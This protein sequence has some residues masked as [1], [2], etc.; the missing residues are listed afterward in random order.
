MILDFSKYKCCITKNIVQSVLDEQQATKDN[1]EEIIFGKNFSVGEAAFKG[2]SNLKKIEN[3]RFADSI[4]PEAFAECTTL[5]EVDLRYNIDISRRAFAGCSSLNKVIFAP[6]AILNE[7]AFAD[8]PKLKILKNIEKISSCWK[9][10]FSNDSL[11]D[12]GLLSSKSIVQNQIFN[13]H[14]DSMLAQMSSSN[15]DLS[16]LK[17]LCNKILYE[18]HYNFITLRKPTVV[19]VYRGQDK[20]YYYMLLEWINNFRQF[21]PSNVLDLHIVLG[22]DDYIE[23]VE[24]TKIKN[25]LDCSFDNVFFHINKNS[26]YIA[27][28][29]IFNV[30]FEDWSRYTNVLYCDVDIVV[31]KPLD[32]LFNISL[33]DGKWL[34]CVPNDPPF[35][36]ENTYKYYS[37]FIPEQHQ[38]K[39]QMFSSTP[40]FNGGMFMFYTKDLA[41]IQQHINEHNDFIYE[42]QC[43]RNQHILNYVFYGKT[44][45]IDSRYNNL[46]KLNEF[47]IDPADAFINHYT[48]CGTEKLYSNILNK[49]YCILQNNNNNK[50]DNNISNDNTNTAISSVESGSI[51]FSIT[52]YSCNTEDVQQKADD[53]N[54]AD[55]N[56][57]FDKSKNKLKVTNFD[58]TKDY[59]QFD[60]IV[61]FDGEM[62]RTKNIVHYKDEVFTFKVNFSQSLQYSADD[63]KNF[64]DD[65]LKHSKAAAQFNNIEIDI[66]P[67]FNS[68]ICSA[69]TNCRYMLF[70]S[71]G[72]DS[73]AIAELLKDSIDIQQFANVF[74]LYDDQ[75]TRDKHFAVQLTLE[76]IESQQQKK[77][78]FHVEK[79]LNNKSLMFEHNNLKCLRYL[80]RKTFP[81]ALYITGDV[82]CA[83]LANVDTFSSTDVD[84]LYPYFMQS[85]LLGM[86]ILLKK[87]QSMYT[88]LTMNSVGK[89]VHKLVLLE[90]LLTHKHDVVCD[91]YDRIKKSILNKN[92]EL[93]DKII[94]QIIH[95]IEG[96]YADFIDEYK[97]ILTKFYPNDL[98]KIDKLKIKNGSKLLNVFDSMF[99]GDHFSV[100]Q[101]IWNLTFSKI[102]D[103]VLEQNLKNTFNQLNIPIL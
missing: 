85:E 88:S 5:E 29:N 84:I 59:L 47:N 38:S 46:Y 94:K 77:F 91:N 39:F 34:A 79:S 80:L 15:N 98:D 33:D 30:F 78:V 97:D 57:E 17:E 20:C 65:Y 8:C 6:Y 67:T 72:I 101:K 55:A 7:E 1:I 75:K 43:D 3:I 100:N 64:I 24:E 9:N 53:I 16:K 63:I 31:N 54:V 49:L 22:K 11:V 28:N 51:K 23:I 103:S 86:Y 62:P 48:T 95:S 52:D 2:F 44:Q 102:K 74:I 66:D 58:A 70:N 73:L 93:N 25:L 68:G 36:K 50:A 26:K 81:N 92:P 76:Q 99:N 10:T 35:K 19:T 83:Q 4:L 89:Q 41:A 96:A 12:N 61:T 21:Y 69:D 27:N 71:G 18:Y 32:S 40:M 90:Y 60:F 45:F 14:I 56:L 13:E 82:H 37:A 87:K 42:I